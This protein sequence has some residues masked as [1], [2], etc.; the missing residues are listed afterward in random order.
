MPS[1]QASQ[2]RL[3]LPVTI[4]AAWRQVWVDGV[5]RLGSPITELMW[6]VKVD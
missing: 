4:S 1:N 2:E 6:F 3:H 5:G